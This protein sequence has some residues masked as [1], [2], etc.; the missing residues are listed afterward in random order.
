[1]NMPLA[2]LALSLVLFVSLFGLAFSLLWPGLERQQEESAMAPPMA[3][4]MWWRVL[5]PCLVPLARWPGSALA[6]LDHDQVHK[7]LQAAGLDDVLTVEQIAACR[8]ALTLLL[9]V[10]VCI[11]VG[12]DVLLLPLVGGA[13]IVLGMSVPRLLLHRQ[14]VD[15]RQRIVRE[16]PF[17]LELLTLC[18]EAGMS[19]TTAIGQLLNK[20]P[21]GALSAEW[22]RVLH[23]INAGRSRADALRAMARRV[24]SPAVASVVAALVSA[25]RSGASIGTVLRNQAAQRRAERFHRA[26]TLAMQAPTRMLLPLIVFIF[27]CTFLI[28]LFP[29]ALRIQQQGFL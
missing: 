5:A 12:F 8:L 29:I 20:G 16:L 7:H 26:E 2:L 19:W 18:I 17:H 9:L 21:A 22:R 13:A 4:P 15:R 10:C 1:M 11:S 3:T 6:R 27:P 24:S 14:A 28:L 25:E 23:D